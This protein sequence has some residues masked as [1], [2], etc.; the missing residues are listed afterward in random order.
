MSSSLS[1][2]S[3]KEL[4]AKLRALG[5]GGPYAGGKHLFMT[6]DDLQLT[7]PNP[8]KSDISVALLSRLLKQASISKEEWGEA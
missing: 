7:I 8:H 5:F 6:K 4:I 1:S 3:H 2:V